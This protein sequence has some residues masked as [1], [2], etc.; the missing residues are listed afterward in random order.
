VT[1]HASAKAEGD[2]TIGRHCLIQAH[3][4]IGHDAKLGDNVTVA[5]FAC[6]GGHSV[7]RQHANLGLHA[8]L[9]QFTEVGEGAMVGACA[10]A[11]ALPTVS[12][13][14]ASWMPTG[15]AG[16]SSA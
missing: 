15:A 7:V 13:T 3:A 10:F 16:K 5:C 14:P 11:K 8:V 6:V 2:T 12:C 1:I 9:H 4:H